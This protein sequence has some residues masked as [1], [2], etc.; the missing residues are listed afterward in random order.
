[1]RYSTSY[2]KPGPKSRG[3][4]LTAPGI[5]FRVTPPS[6]N[7]CS[8][9]SMIKWV[10]VCPTWQDTVL[11]QADFKP[12]APQTQGYRK[13]PLSHSKGSSYWDSNPVPLLQ[14]SVLLPSQPSTTTIVHLLSVNSADSTRSHILRDRISY[15]KLLLVTSQAIKLGFFSSFSYAI[16][17][18][19]NLL[20]T[21][22][23]Y[24]DVLLWYD[25]LLEAKH[26]LAN[27]HAIAI[28]A[29][30]QGRHYT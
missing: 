28:A 18:Y 8:L 25:E 22:E 26:L 30:L 10:P 16:R 6:T 23:R 29:C 20:L 19:G 13:E 14:Q 3:H 11:P 1:M 2:A 7:Q 17:N 21:K 24:D 5:L 4:L 27:A 15:G 12:R 9:T